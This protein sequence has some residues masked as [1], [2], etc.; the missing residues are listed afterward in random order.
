MAKKRVE[1]IVIGAGLIGLC[2]ALILGKLKFNVILID[3]NIIESTKHLETDT[4]TIAISYGTKIL[5]EK[6]NIWRKISKEA[7]PINIIKVLNRTISSKILFDTDH[8]NNPMGFIVKNS[9]FKKV[10]INEI[11]KI[12]NIKKLQGNKI[13]E[14]KHNE[15]EVC[16]L[17]DKK[18]LLK[19][20]L[21]IGADGKNSFINANSSL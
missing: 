18:L 12:K 3:K 4:R 15:N 6:Y 14:I 21:L 19:A 13:I 11:N 17:T 16:V 10:L 5:L 7:Q 20:K 1:I 8:I 2:S 9:V